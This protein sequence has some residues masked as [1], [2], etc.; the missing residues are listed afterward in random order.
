MMCKLKKAKGIVAIAMRKVS[1]AQAVTQT[2]AKNQ[3]LRMS[4]QRMPF[5]FNLI[6]TKIVK[7]IIKSEEAFK[8]IL[9]AQKKKHKCNKKNRLATNLI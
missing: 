4:I 6:K 1:R 9:K 3:S 8:V 7:F 5:Q 2:R